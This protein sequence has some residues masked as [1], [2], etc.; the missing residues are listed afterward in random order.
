MNSNP[1]LTI[2]V[3]NQLD[4]PLIVDS[5][6][7]PS[8]I[9]LPTTFPGGYAPIYIEGAVMQPHD[10]AT[11]HGGPPGLRSVAL[12]QSDHFPV[13]V[14]VQE[15]DG[16]TFTV[17]PDDLAAAE[18][19]L[20]FYRDYC[21]QPFSPVARQFNDVVLDPKNAA[22]FAE[23]VTRFLAESGYMGATAPLLGAVSYWTANELFA[24]PGTYTAYEPPPLAAGGSFPLP[25]RAAGQMVVADGKASFTA[26]GGGTSYAS[27]SF[28]DGQ[29]TSP[30]ARL[31]A[32]SVY[33]TLAWEQQPA[34]AALFFTGTR[35]GKPFIL[36]P[37]EAVSFPWWIAA[38]DLAFTSLLGTRIV[39][40]MDMAAT[41]LRTIAGGTA[42]LTKNA[43]AL[44]GNVRA[45][46][47]RI[48]DRADPD[49]TAGTDVDVINVDVD[50]DIDIDVD[51][52][53][54]TTVANLDID[55]DTGPDIDAIVDT[56]IDT[57]LTVPPGAID[58][59]FSS[60]GAWITTSEA[61]A[62]VAK[63]V[64]SGQLRGNEI[65]LS[66]WNGS[67][68]EDL[69]SLS[70]QQTIGLG[71][72]INFMVHPGLSAQERWSTFADWVR[73]QRPDAL[74]QE[75][76]LTSLVMFQNDPADRELASWSWDPDAENTLLQQM[77][78]FKAPEQ[79]F[80]AYLALGAAT[81]NDGQALPVK[82]AANVARKYLDAIG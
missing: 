57:S 55:I 39:A 1:F 82:L 9:V 11:L 31:A 23:Q 32:S 8:T 35:D 40:T 20:R 71:L 29:L 75:I 61:P 17:T 12:R 15:T 50:I 33:R 26:A 4:V 65:L 67:D 79:Q 73:R 34:Q 53:T 78:Q 5:T 58:A 52:E 56:E 64:I 37:Y 6:T 69:A 41:V 68:E 36:Q 13:K 63:A 24:W 81:A 10:T 7:P 19:A 76:L 59:A 74:S 14:F 44:Y 22:T 54:D 42:W 60:L 45:E 2:T 48:G 3:A 46:L 38:Y 25:I 72:V 80:N 66:P 62:V 47:E 16:Q 77:A 27:L 51:I 43:A 30:D 49:A 18:A 21:S 70:P 28:A